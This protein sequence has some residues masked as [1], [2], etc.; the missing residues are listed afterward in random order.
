MLARFAEIMALK[1]GGTARAP[2][3]P[4]LPSFDLAGVAALINSG[5]VRRIIC[6]CGAGISVSAG[7]PDFRSPG[8]GLYSRLQE[9]NLPHPQ[10]VFEIDFFRRNPR[11]FYLLAKELFPGTYAPTPTHHFIRLLHDKGLLLRCYTQN[12]DS[13]EAQAGLPYDKVIAAHGNFDSAHCIACK[14]KHEVE[15]VRSA[16][17]AQEPCYCATGKKGCKGLVKPAIVF[18]GESL[19]ERFWKCVPGDFEQA[20]LLIVLGT[21]LVVQPFASLIGVPRIQRF[22]DCCSILQSVMPFTLLWLCRLCEY[23]WAALPHASPSAACATSSLHMLMFWLIDWC[24]P[25][26]SSG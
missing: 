21:S 24:H 5:R 11:P 25:C 18:F 8:T 14:A 13:L 1:S 6:M 15:Y 2:P 23:H 16:V 3:S 4:L 26:R 17:M 12:I 22:H 19:P 9:Y 7:I 20:D 10:A